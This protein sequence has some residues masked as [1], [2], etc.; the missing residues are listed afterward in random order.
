[1]KIKL[2][3]L[4]LQNRGLELESE[5]EEERA[6]LLDLWLK[7]GRPVC[8]TRVPKGVIHGTGFDYDIKGNVRL[9]IAPSA[10]EED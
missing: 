9:S 8:L 10:A 3:T 7:K 6:V 2:E 5:T 1:M 4:P